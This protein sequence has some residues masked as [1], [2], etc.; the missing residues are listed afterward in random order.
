[1]N[2][3]D[4]TI[5][6]RHCPDLKKFMD[7]IGWEPG[8]K[9]CI[10]KTA[11]MYALENAKSFYSRKAVYILLKN[12]WNINDMD[13][14]GNHALSYALDVRRWSLGEEL[15]KRYKVTQEGLVN[16]LYEALHT[17][18]FGYKPM[19][20]KVIMTIIRQ[21]GGITPGKCPLAMMFAYG[22]RAIPYIAPMAC[23]GFTID[24]Q[25]YEK[26]Y[27]PEFDVRE[28]IYQQFMKMNEPFQFHNVDGYP[29]C[30]ENGVL[31]A[32]PEWSGR[33]WPHLSRKRKKWFYI[34]PSVHAL[35]DIASWTSRLSRRQE[36][37]RA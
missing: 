11:L 28:G 6:L 2:K 33:L 9:D 4:K 7:E 18:F 30:V 17:Y 25:Q 34:K 23:A 8:D 29:L 3:Q 26:Y 12:G 27:S 10:G 24:P 20:D 31:H 22:G 5:I 21:L 36:Q 37:A 16:C 19:A 13:D 1:M 15:L 14:G 35:N 32:R